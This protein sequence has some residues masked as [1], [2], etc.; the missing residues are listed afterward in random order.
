MI[1]S[2]FVFEQL[3]E[4]T[5][6]IGGNAGNIKDRKSSLPPDDQS[7]S[8]AANIIRTNLYGVVMQQQPG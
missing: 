2:C 8:A 3:H 4:Q 7:L 6:A 5:G 1:D